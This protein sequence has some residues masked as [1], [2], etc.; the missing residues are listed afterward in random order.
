MFLNVGF[1]I[2]QLWL[3]PTDQE[4]AVI[5]KDGLL[6]FPRDEDTYHSARPHGKASIRFC[7]EAERVRGKRL[8][9]SLLEK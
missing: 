5:W 8:Y 2:T 1:I 3:R 9:Y 4:T 6:Q 7:Q